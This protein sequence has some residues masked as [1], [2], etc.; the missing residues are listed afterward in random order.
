MLLNFSPNEHYQKQC[1]ISCLFQVTCD[2]CVSSYVRQKRYLRMPS[3]QCST[4]FSF[5]FLFVFA[6][7][8]D[9][10]LQRTFE[11]SP[12]RFFFS[13]LFA[14]RRDPQG[15]GPVFEPWTYR[16]ASRRANHLVTPLKYYLKR[17]VS[18]HI[19]VHD[20][21]CLRISGPDLVPEVVDSSRRPQWSVLLHNEDYEI[22]GFRSRI[23][24][25]AFLD[26][27]PDPDLHSEYGF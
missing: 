4:F 2:M 27:L 1:I 23:R 14:L 3:S 20:D 25:G 16:M 19:A 11:Q 8:S 17:K 5:F 7:L 12:S 24:I 22:P 26:E 10:H 21:E 18:T 13:S 15:A 9:P 6:L